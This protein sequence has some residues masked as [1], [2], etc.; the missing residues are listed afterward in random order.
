MSKSKL[1][2]CVIDDAGFMKSYIEKFSP[3]SEVTQ[4]F[5]IPDDT[6]CLSE[7]DVLVVDGQGIGNGKFRNGFEFLNAYEATGSNARVIYHSGN[8]VY[9]AERDALLK[10]GFFNVTKGNPEKLVAC[11]EEVRKLERPPRK[12]GVKDVKKYGKSW[13]NELKTFGIG[14][15]IQWFREVCLERDSLRERLSETGK[16]EREGESA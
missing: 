7:Y 9:G 12:V 6:A 13:E 4:M 3:D 15:V 14:K 8:G 2:I 16:N 1:K 11:I 10:K 5:R